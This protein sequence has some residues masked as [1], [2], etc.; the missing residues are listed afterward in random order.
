ML[1]TEEDMMKDTSSIMMRSVHQP[2]RGCPTGWL[3]N[4]LSIIP[5]SNAVSCPLEAQGY[6]SVVKVN[7]TIQKAMVKFKERSAFHEK[8]PEGIYVLW[9]IHLANHAT[10]GCVF[11]RINPGYS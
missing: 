11:H 5:G 6:T 9:G 8:I 10:T 3:V 1:F 7:G 2:Y 4:S